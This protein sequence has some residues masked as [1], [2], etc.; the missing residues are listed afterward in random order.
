MKKLH[1]AQRYSPVQTSLGTTIRDHQRPFSCPIQKRH[2]HV[3]LGLYEFMRKKL[4][5]IFIR[6]VLNITRVDDPFNI[7][8]N[9]Y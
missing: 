3:V 8:P 7:N 4:K 6:R 2:G 1:I 9:C 5:E